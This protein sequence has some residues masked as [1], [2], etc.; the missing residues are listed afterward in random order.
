M[1]INLVHQQITQVCINWIV[2]S[3]GTQVTKDGYGVSY[4]IPGDYVVYFHISSWKSSTLTVSAH[5]HANLSYGVIVAL[6]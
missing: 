5:S 2:V 6:K 1:S 3:M 4:I